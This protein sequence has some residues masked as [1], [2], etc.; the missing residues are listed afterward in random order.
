MF[1]PIPNSFHRD[2]RIFNS[3]TV[4]T[5]LLDGTTTRY[6]LL[7][8]ATKSGSISQLSF[9]VQ[10]LTSAQTVKVSIQTVSSGQPSGTLW[11][12]NTSGT[13]TPVSGATMAVTL[14]AN[15]TVTAGQVFAIVVEWNSTAGSI[16]LAT[17]ENFGYST[18]FQYA[19]ATWTRQPAAWLLCLIAYAD[20]TYPPEMSLYFR[21]GAAQ[22][23]SNTGAESALNFAP[24][25]NYRLAGVYTYGFIVNCAFRLYDSSTNLLQTDTQKLSFASDTTER[26]Q[27]HPLTAYQLIKGQRYRLSIFPNSATN[28]RIYASGIISASHEH[29][30]MEI[31]DCYSV[32]TAGTG[33]WTDQASIYIP[34]IIPVYD[35]VATSSNSMSWSGGING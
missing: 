27:Y 2:P 15:A 35:G 1:T 22:N 7:V 9:F 12:T 16:S 31:G 8:V 34:T 19:S 11:A 4:T 24:A 32:R 10:S 25:H 14:T 5:A 3:S 33:G 18:Q 30:G 13:A 29:L 28:S 20:G 21:T 23:F 17:N 6:A 26:W